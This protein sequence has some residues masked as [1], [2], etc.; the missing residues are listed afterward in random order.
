M[1]SNIV[2]KVQGS[3]PSPY[4]V[5]VQFEP[6]TTKEKQEILKIITGNIFY[7]SQLLNG[8]LPQTLFET[9]KQHNISVLP[10]SWNDL[11][12]DCSCPDWAVPCKH[13]AGVL[14]L[15]VNE[16]D[17]DP[18][19]I[20]KTKGLDLLSELEKL[21][22]HKSDSAS[23]ILRFQDLIDK[24]NHQE[25]TSETP[26]DWNLFE[27]DFSSI[28]D[29]E[30]RIFSLL[31]ANPLFYLKS[32][33]KEILRKGYKNLK[34]S[35]LIKTYFQEE[36]Q[37]PSKSKILHYNEIID[38]THYDVKHLLQ[39][40]DTLNNKNLYAQSNEYILLY[41]VYHFSKVLASKCAFIPKIVQVEENLYNLWYVPAVLDEPVQ[42]IY[43][44][45]L[46]VFTLDLVQYSKVFLPK[47]L[48]LQYLISSFIKY[49]FVL[50]N[51]YDAKIPRDEIGN[52]FFSREFF[53]VKRFED[54]NIPAN[55]HLWLSRFS[56]STKSYKIVLKVEE[57][58][59]D[60]WVN[61][62]LENEHGELQGLSLYSQW[63]EK[64]EI[65]KDL[66]I[67]TDYFQ[68]LEVV[69]SSLWEKELI[70]WLAELSSL[71]YEKIPLLKMLGVKI[72]I[73]KT[74]QKI[75]KPT[76]S[77][78]AKSKGNLSVQSYLGLRELVDF[79]WELSLGDE[80]VSL[81]EMKQLLSQY[82]G[83]MKYKDSF[84]Y[85]ESGEI[86][87]LLKKA[88]Q[89]PDFSDWEVQQMLIGE[90]FEW[91]EISF[92]EELK[93]YIKS[94]KKIDEI[95]LPTWVQA[96]LRPYQKSW[97]DW[98]YKN[99]KLWFWS[100]LADDMGLWK[101]LQVICFLLKLK[102]EGITQ[103]SPWIV[104]V[105]TALLSNWTNEIT[106][107]APDLKSM[108]YHGAN[109]T[110][111]FEKTDLIL[112]T[113]GVVRSEVDKLNKIDLSFVI[114][115]E[116]QN[117]KNTTTEQ[118]KAVKKLKSPI[119][120]AMSGTP[121][122]NRLSEYWSLLDFTNKWLFG[123]LKHFTTTFA[124]PIENDRNH[125]V[126]QHFKKVSAPFILR[127]LK[128]DKSII[129][130]LPEKIEI[131]QICS[132]TPQQGAI[133][134]NIINKSL[135][136]IENSEWIERKGLVLK[137]ITNLKQTCN[138]PYQ[139]LK[140]GKKDLELSGKTQTILP[141]LENIYQNNEKVL[142]FTQYEE[143]WKLLQWLL[144]D[145]FGQEILF[146]YG[147][148]DRK[149]RDEMIQ[150]FQTK[151]ECK[152]LI[153]S[154][155]AWGTGLNLVGANHVIHYDLWRNPAVESQATDRAYRIGQNKNVFV[156]R[157]ITQWTFE[158]KIN[159]MLL[160]KKEL[161]NLTLSQWENWIGDLSN[162]D[163]REVFSLAKQEKE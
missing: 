94:L 52:L 117:I 137:M 44:S 59:W 75:Y 74:L 111:D 141:L 26:K 144:G 114:I 28:W 16:I 142:I 138:H 82:Q 101:T 68:E 158:E 48:Q 105:P 1:W 123:W 163:L 69:I 31:F 120:I 127:R 72:I 151:N 79:E 18:F 6:F 125:Q 143:M 63:K 133:Y 37:S 78:K 9:L 34:K 3:R 95:A 17:K 121:V 80:K 106:K 160:S 136:V 27:V 73:P 97:Y 98:L 92:D 13:L 10:N 134:E 29:T 113:Y 91:N 131:D 90:S 71:M 159:T 89:S 30:E 23:K 145:K 77:L 135:E 45:L 7:I 152:T 20:F 49:F 150:K 54:Q 148:L 119:K 100:I 157:C 149:K 103:K 38:I 57:K 24:N 147:G 8:K 32:D 61:I 66:S 87:K 76:L 22:L 36:D 39:T 56:L 129:S 122:E 124:I 83:M 58:I 126:I 43:E 42:K 64:Y 21:D 70:L 55:I 116:A 47:P 115:D 50:E 4:K 102:L 51:K 14:Y 112:T 88:Q 108:I 19:L 60:F 81:E 156:Y 154:L 41:H 53:H 153:L 107:F 128:T 25:Y 110:A 96:H 93:S 140:T 99:Y 46:E 12:G 5:E 85:L 33:F 132:L 155:R 84:V 62:L 104:I 109:R 2:A 40:L 15:I 35:Q 65:L 86:E 11:H 146:Y 162:A 130:D 139:Y 67:L 118:T 161:S